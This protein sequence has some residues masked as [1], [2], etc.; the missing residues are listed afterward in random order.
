MKTRNLESLFRSQKGFND[1]F[2]MPSLDQFSNSKNDFL[3]NLHVNPL[4]GRPQNRKK[5][6][7]FKLKVLLPPMIINEMTQLGGFVS[8][9]KRFERYFRDDLS[10]SIFRLQNWLYE[11]LYT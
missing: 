3:K 8:V 5:Y 7:F 4:D 2:A 6:D 10:K 9:S 11:E 1:T